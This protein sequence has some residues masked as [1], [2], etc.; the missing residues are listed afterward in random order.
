MFTERSATENSSGSNQSRLCLHT[1]CR[2]CRG[3][4]AGVTK[5]L[6]SAPP[7]YFSTTWL[8]FCFKDDYTVI[9]W[10]PWGND[11][12]THRDTTI[13]RL[14][15]P[16]VQPPRPAPADSTNHG[17]CT[18]DLWTTWVWTAWVHLHVYFLQLI[19]LSVNPC[20]TD[21]KKNPHIWTRR[22]Q[23]HIVQRSTTATCFH[24]EKESL[25]KSTVF[26][27]LPWWFSG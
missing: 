2:Q 13:C 9:S 25:L 10:Y 23:T 19:C 20:N 16:L 22:V 7:F 27:G 18:T 15:S 3:R 24:S 26:W 5:R 8:D 12:R 6:V 1:G 14:S 21:K 11:S 17:S 4:E